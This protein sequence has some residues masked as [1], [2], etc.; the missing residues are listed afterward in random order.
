MKHSPKQLF[1]ILEWA[2][3]AGALQIKVG[4]VEVLFPPTG[5]DAATRPKLT[6]TELEFEEVRRTGN[7]LDDPDMYASEFNAW[8]AV[9]P[10]PKP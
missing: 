3:M 4:D 8:S 2:K 9:K 10:L 6:Q 1:A 5:P 7:P